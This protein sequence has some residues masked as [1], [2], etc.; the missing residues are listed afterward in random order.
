MCGIRST[1][2]SCLPAESNTSKKAVAASLS[3]G[4]DFY[5][6]KYE[7]VVGQLGYRPSDKLQL[8]LQANYDVQLGEVTNL[9]TLAKAAPL[10]G[11]QVQFGSGYDLLE[12]RWERLDAATT[13][14]LPWG[15]T[16]QHLISYDG[17]T[18]SLTYNDIALTKD[19]HCRGTDPAVQRGSGGDLAGV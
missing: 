12:E 13:A 1:T 15:L 14:Q 5:A 17:A 16:L 9:Y 6:G 19:L 7:D 8:D 18:D 3:T 10:T 4:Y 2:R 11:W